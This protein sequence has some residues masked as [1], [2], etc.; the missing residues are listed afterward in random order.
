[1][2]T[3]GSDVE[4]KITRKFWKHRYRNLVLKVTAYIKIEFLIKFWKPPNHDCP[5]A[6]KHGQLIIFNDLI[7]NTKVDNR[8][9]NSQMSKNNQTDN[10]FVIYLVCLHLIVG[11]NI[12]LGLPNSKPFIQFSKS[13]FIKQSIYF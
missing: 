8:K 1:M 9:I 12:M 3:E 11:P 13:N 6:T 10:Q 5:L 2:R 7:A 4:L